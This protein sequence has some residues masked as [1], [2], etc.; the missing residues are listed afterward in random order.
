MPRGGPAGAPSHRS[1]P[2]STGD[3]TLATRWRLPS[4]P[5]RRGGG[6]GWQEDLRGDRTQ[7]RPRAPPASSSGRRSSPSSRADS[8]G[9]PQRWWGVQTYRTAPLT[10]ELHWRRRR[11]LPRGRRGETSPP[12]LTMAASSS[13]FPLRTRSTSRSRRRAAHSLAWTA[14]ARLPT[15]AR[16][17]LLCL[18]RLGYVPSPLRPPSPR[19]TQPRGQRSRHQPRQL[20]PKGLGGRW[21]TSALR[22][23]RRGCRSQTRSPRLPSSFPSTS[24]SRWCRQ[25]LSRLGGE[26][27][28]SRQTRHLHTRGSGQMKRCS[29]APSTWGCRTRPGSLT[30]PP[31][32]SMSRP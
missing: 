3:P 25:G 14:H 5:A 21:A 17:P 7:L 31:L 8:V 30:P 11:R 18:H 16:L 9:S 20:P 27:S 26:A 24:P 29:F 13:V 12:P 23:G 4:R 1:R 2:T 28:S 15:P 19:S 6:V 32:T 10:C 22:T